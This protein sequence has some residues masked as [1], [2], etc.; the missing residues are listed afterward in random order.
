MVL[1]LSHE[2]TACQTSIELKLQTT[3]TKAPHTLHIT[4]YTL[5]ITPL[6]TYTLLL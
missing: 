4:H 5:H 3:H 1:L 6:L 2:I